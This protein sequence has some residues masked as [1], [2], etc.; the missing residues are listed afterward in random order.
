MQQSRLRATR[1]TARQQQQLAAQAAG[2]IKQASC[3]LEL[4]RCYFLHLQSLVESS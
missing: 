4:L 3:T 1:Q 2:Q